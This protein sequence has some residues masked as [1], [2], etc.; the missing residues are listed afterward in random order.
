MVK[1]GVNGFFVR[2]RNSKEIAEKVSLLM[3]NDVLRKKMGERA[4][5]TVLER[6]TWAKIAERFEGMYQEFRKKEKIILPP[7]IV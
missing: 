2:P 4:R 7:K 6:F 3:S 1:D 5:Q